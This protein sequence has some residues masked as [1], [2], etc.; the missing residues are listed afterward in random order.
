LEQAAASGSANAELWLLLAEARRQTGDVPGAGLAA[1]QVLP[2]DAGGVSRID[3]QLLYGTSMLAQGHT[4]EALASFR[5]AQRLAP[6]EPRGY[7]LEARL[8]ATTGSW[9]QARDAV[10]RGLR[11]IPAIPRSRRPPRRSRG[12]CLLH[13]ESGADPARERADQCP[14]PGCD[15]SRRAFT[16]RTDSPLRL[17]CVTSAS[18]L[19]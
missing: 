12:R 13:A 5:E 7:D 4:A 6:R 17:E 1:Q 11:A 8:H 16:T 19:S 10:E 2:S 9:A 15:R 14:V 3:A 18:F